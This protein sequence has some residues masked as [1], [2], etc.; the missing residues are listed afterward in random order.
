MESSY[1][2]STA[3]AFCWM[4]LPAFWVLIQPNLDLSHPLMAVHFHVPLESTYLV[5]CR[6]LPAFGSMLVQLSKLSFHWSW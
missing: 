2:S 1:W 6:V 5:A 4:S 3:L